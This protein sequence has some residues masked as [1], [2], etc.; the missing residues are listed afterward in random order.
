MPEI[1]KTSLC[2][3]IRATILQYLSEWL[4]SP[5]LWLQEIDVQ[6]EL[7]IRISQILRFK[8][9][10]TIEAQHTHCSGYRDFSRLTCEPYVV[11]KQPIKY[12]HPDIVIWDGQDKHDF[13]NNENDE[14]R[15][16]DTINSGKWPIIWV[17]EIKYTAEKP[18]DLDKNRLKAIL[19]NKT[20]F[21]ACWIKMQLEKNI[22]KDE[23][24]FKQEGKLC[25][26]EAKKKEN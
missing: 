21:E 25:L 11:L 20:A 16:I 12:A 5:Y 3:Q 23:I 13:N 2:N 6:I 19:D 15:T 24:S 26:F 17:C 7:A 1:D 18:D 8:G 14:N 9:I 4:N 22:S 10:D